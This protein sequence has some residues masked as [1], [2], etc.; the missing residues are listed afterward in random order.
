[1]CIFRFV[2]YGFQYERNKSFC[3]DITEGKFSFPVI[4]GV[5][6]N[7]QSTQLISELHVQCVPL[8]DDLKL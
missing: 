4:H 5:F 2:L 1:M 3:E 7:L 8:A 6:S